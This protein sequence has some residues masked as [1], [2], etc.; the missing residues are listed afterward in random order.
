MANSRRTISSNKRKRIDDKPAAQTA[1]AK[2]PKEIFGQLI[3][4]A[5]HLPADLSKKKFRVLTEK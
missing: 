1:L 5:S 3:G 2:R 4:K